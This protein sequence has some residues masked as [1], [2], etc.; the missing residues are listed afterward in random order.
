MTSYPDEYVLE[1]V[2]FLKRYLSIVPEVGIVTGSGFGGIVDEI[3]APV[4]YMLRG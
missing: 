3:E 1:A 2:A 4:H